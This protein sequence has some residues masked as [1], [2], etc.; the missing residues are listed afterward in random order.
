[1][2]CRICEACSVVWP[3]TPVMTKAY[4]SPRYRCAAGSGLAASSS[5]WWRACR[6]PV[7]GRGRCSPSAPHA[8]TPRA[9][10]QGPA[11]GDAPRTAAAEP[12]HRTHRRRR[13]R[14]SPA[15]ARRRSTACPTVRPIAGPTRPDVRL[16]PPD[17]SPGKGTR[18]RRPAWRR[19]TCWPPIARPGNRGWH[20]TE[21]PGLVRNRA[22]G[23]PPTHSPWARTLRRERGGAQGCENDVG[24]HA[25]PRT[26][27]RAMPG[28][29]AKQEH[30]PS[31]ARARAAGGPA[32]QLRTGK[33]ASVAALVSALRGP[34]QPPRATQRR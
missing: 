32:L 20:P 13:S 26:G 33:W 11:S 5:G 23:S 28:S 31:A 1:M 17:S 21:G 9:G 22:R 24:R 14:A 15:H 34:G 18:G 29:T 27:V 3:M 30:L 12:T 10:S 19:S 6:A 4:G 8:T 7:A 25:G 2:N 16:A